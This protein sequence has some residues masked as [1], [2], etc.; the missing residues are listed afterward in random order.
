M[1]E[2]DEAPYELAGQGD[3]EAIF[4]G[5]G[6]TIRNLKIVKLGTPTTVEGRIYRNFLEG[7]QRYYF[8]QCQFC[9]GMQILELK[10]LGRDYGLTAR[11]EKGWN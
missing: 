2:I 10:G 8:V 9:G 4:A 3:T 11:S 6:K 1:D 5:R 7:D